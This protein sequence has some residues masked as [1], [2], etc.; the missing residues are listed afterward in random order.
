MPEIFTL[1]HKHFWKCLER[2]LYMLANY[3][4]SQMWTNCI[5]EKGCGAFIDSFHCNN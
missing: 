4:K 5:Y 1:A 3:D 2:K